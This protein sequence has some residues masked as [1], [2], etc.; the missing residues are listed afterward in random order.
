[1]KIECDTLLNLKII[2][3]T[4]QDIV[5]LQEFCVTAFKEY[6]DLRNSTV[7][8]APDDSVLSEMVHQNENAD[9]LIENDY[10]FSGEELEY[11]RIQPHQY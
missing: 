11:L 1:M 2:P 6:P 7:F 9:G 5:Y 3:E 4:P 10:F 8:M